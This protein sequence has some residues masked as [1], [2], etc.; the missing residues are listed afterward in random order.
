MVPH[1]A[2]LMR[3]KIDSPDGHFGLENRAREKSDFA[4]PF[5]LIWAVQSLAQKFS[6]FAFPEIDVCFPHSAPTQGAYRDRHET[7]CGVRWTQRR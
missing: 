3:A 7:W 4:R 2:A 1:V 6:I 5:K